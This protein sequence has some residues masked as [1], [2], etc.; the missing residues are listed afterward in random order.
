MPELDLR[1]I[2]PFFLLSFWAMR[3]YFWR[4]RR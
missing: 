3:W 1:V 4:R 2:I